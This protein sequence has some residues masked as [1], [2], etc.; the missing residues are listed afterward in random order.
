MK[1]LYK[2]STYQILCFALVAILGL[3]FCLLNLMSNNQNSCVYSAKAKQENHTDKIALPIIMYHSTYHKNTGKY[4]LHPDQLEKDF[5]YIKQNGYTAI[6]T[7]DLLNFVHSNVP[8]PDKPIMLTFDDGAKT[9]YLYAYPLLKKYNLKAVFAVVGKWADDEELAKGSSLSYQMI[10][11]MHESGLVEIQSH[12][13]DMHK[14]KGR[15]GMSKNKNESDDEYRAAL[16]ADLEM[17]K[18]NLY[19]KLGIK[20][21]AVAYP[22]GAFCALSNE[23]LRELG[24]K[25]AFICTEKVN[26]IDKNSD[27][28]LLGRYNRPNGISSESFFNKLK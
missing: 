13:Y 4:V 17:V 18:N 1:K 28:F 15:V 24:Y 2:P 22:F 7:N 27:L 14:S 8:L 5:I 10:K 11:E 6:N 26:Y 9:N 16:K 19:N 20:V 23:I 12:S 3:S 25:A 21:T